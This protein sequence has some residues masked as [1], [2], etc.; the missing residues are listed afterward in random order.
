MLLVVSPHLDDAVLSVGQLLANYPTPVVLT[1]F[2][3]SPA[4]GMAASSYDKNCGFG[5]PEAGMHA[6]WSEDDRA[7]RILG[8]RPARAPLIDHQYRTGDPT[9]AVID[10]IR[11]TAQAIGATTILGPLGLN[12]PDHE[13]VSRAMR[14]TADLAD[15]W[16]YEDIPSRVMT[17][18]A[19]HTAWED[20]RAAGFDLDLGFLGDGPKDSKRAALACYRSQTWALDPDC[21]FVPER[22]WRLTRP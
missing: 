15:L 8:C 21:C 1:I 20:H 22:L 18:E 9:A 19:V 13:I 7:L 12:H 3:G 5:S 4:P 11:Q 10:I 14:E 16:L 6:R 2:A 17:P